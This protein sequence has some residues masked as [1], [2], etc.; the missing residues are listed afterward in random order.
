MYV[1]ADVVRKDTIKNGLTYSP[2]SGRLYSYEE[3]VKAIEDADITVE[4]GVGAWVLD[5]MEADETIVDLNNK[6]VYFVDRF[7]VTWEKLYE[8]F[9][10]RMAFSWYSLW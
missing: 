7:L 1:I 10:D 9:G 5:G 4:D 2:V 8:K 3:F 6:A